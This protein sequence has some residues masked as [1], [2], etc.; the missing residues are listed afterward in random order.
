MKYIIVIVLIVIILLLVFLLSRRKKNNS[1]NKTSSNIILSAANSTTCYVD[2]NNCNTDCKGYRC[3]ENCVRSSTQCQ[4]GETGCYGSEQ[5]CTDSCTPVYRCNS[6]S[7]VLKEYN[8]CVSGEQCYTGTLDNANANCVKT[9]SCIGSGPTGATGCNTS[10]SFGPPC[11][12]SATNCYNS[13]TSCINTCKGYRC[14]NC[15]MAGAKCDGTEPNCYNTSAACSTGAGSCPSVY[16]CSDNCTASRTACTDTELSQGKCYTSAT[17]CQNFCPATYR[18]TP[19][20]KCNIGYVSC[21]GGDNTC[22]SNSTNCKYSLNQDC[23]KGYRC[24]AKCAP[25]RMCDLNEE[26]CHETPALCIT[27]CKGYRCSDNCE[28]KQGCTP[29]D[30]T[31]YV[32]K[33]LCNTTCIP[34]SCD[35]NTRT[36]VRSY[37]NCTDTGINNKTCFTTTNCLNVCGKTVFDRINA[38]ENLKY[39]ILNVATVRQIS[40]SNS[41]NTAVNLQDNGVYYSSLYNPDQL[42][43][44]KNVVDNKA[45]IVNSSNKR[46]TCISENSDGHCSDGN[47]T[48]DPNS[49]GPGYDKIIIVPSSDLSE[50]DG[51]ICYL[52]SQN[53]R[54]WISLG[55]TDQGWG[56]GNEND[57]RNLKVQWNKDDRFAR[58][59]IFIANG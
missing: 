39:R 52:Y 32:S 15:A 7:G 40:G 43:T 23:Q 49:L 41:N 17:G 46:L 18:C 58:W 13:S 26:G 16:R 5:N 57:P 24:S 59:K 11:A 51:G 56:G 44:F 14:S 6:A 9:Y 47:Y 53:N 3:S 31:C 27:N 38:N 50:R 42:W 4:E 55:W 21:Q 34:Y 45:F 1:I 22:F 8:S 48:Y 19:D 25:E 2:L 36:C 30:S 28:E 12:T 54:G 37:G 20:K 29:E 33:S 10:S 35:M